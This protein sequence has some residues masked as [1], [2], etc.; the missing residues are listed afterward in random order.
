MSNTFTTAEVSDVQGVEAASV[1]APIPE[2]RLA[3]SSRARRRRDSGKTSRSKKTRHATK[4]KR[5]VTAATTKQDLVLQLL[6]RQSGV[7]IDDIVSNTHWQP[8]SVRGFLSGVVRKKYKLPL[9]SEVGKDGVRRYHVA[10]LKPA[11]A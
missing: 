8:H 2:T 1:A 11:K 4:K 6:G 9:V 3:K 5:H 7:S 10:S